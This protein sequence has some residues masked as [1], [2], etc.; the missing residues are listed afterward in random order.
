MLCPKV[1]PKA[2]AT[3]VE[4]ACPDE[5]V[6]DVE[7]EVVVLLKEQGGEDRRTGSY[8]LA[9]D[10]ALPSPRAAA[11]TNSNINKKRAKASSTKLPR[12]R[13]RIGQWRGCSKDCGGGHQT[14]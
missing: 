11:R 9:R 8:R 14:R 7:E 10:R 12:F 4:L 1:Q 2:T 13:W 5:G 3:C 6:Q